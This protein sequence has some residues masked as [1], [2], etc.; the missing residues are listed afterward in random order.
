MTSEQVTELIMNKLFLRTLKHDCNLQIK[1]NTIDYF[2]TFGL[3]GDYGNARGLLLLNSHLTIAFIF[4]DAIANEFDEMC[5]WYEEGDN[6]NKECF[7]CIVIEE[8]IRIDFH[9][10]LHY[11]LSKNKIFDE[12]S[13]SISKLSAPPERCIIS[14]I[15]D[16]INIEVTLS[17]EVKELLSCQGTG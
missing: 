16:K 17:I 4:L 9:E 8:I 2:S 7:E 3:Y 5:Y 13:I 1:E 6:F 12:N 10:F 11:F 14:T 15:T